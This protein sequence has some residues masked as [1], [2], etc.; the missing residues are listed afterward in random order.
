MVLC[1]PAI[2]FGKVESGHVD[3]DY[4]IRNLLGKEIIRRKKLMLSLIYRLRVT[5]LLRLFGIP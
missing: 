1:Y 4:I 5:R 3:K 2:D